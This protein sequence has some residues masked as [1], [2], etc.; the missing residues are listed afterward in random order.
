MKKQLLALSGTV[1]FVGGAVALSM[2]SRAL[3]NDSP[4]PTATEFQPDAMSRN[5]APRAKTQIP[6]ETA[7][8]GY[9]E[10][11]TDLFA[12]M[13]AGVYRNDE[14]LDL[15]ARTWSFSLGGQTT[16]N[17]VFGADSNGNFCNLSENEVVY[18]FTGTI[19]ADKACSVMPVFLVLNTDTSQF[20]IY[21]GT[22]DALTLNDENSLTATFTTRM[23]WTGGNNLPMGVGFYTED[24]EAT[25]FTVTDM[26]FSTIVRGITAEQWSEEKDLPG[27]GL[28]DSWM[29]DSEKFMARDG[30]TT[31]GLCRYGEDY[32]SLSGINT[33][34]TDVTIPEKAV[35]GGKV[36]HIR[37]N[38]E[39]VSYNGNPDWS[40]AASMTT[41][42]FYSTFETWY[43]SFNGSSVSDVFIEGRTLFENTARTDG[44][45][46]YL[47]I[48]KESVSIERRYY[49]GR[50]FT[51]VFVGEETA[52]YPQTD[53]SHYIIANGEGDYFGLYLYDNYIYVAEVFS[54]KENVSLPY[55]APYDGR[56]IWVSGAGL[57]DLI[58]YGTF[59]AH[60]PGMKAI[61]LSEHYD[62]IDI[63]WNYSPLLKELYV[64]GSP[65]NLRWSLNNDMKV[66]VGVQQ[67]FS[68]YEA[69]SNWNRAAI[70]PYGWDFEWMTVN[71]GRKGEFAQTYIEMT[72]ADW[73]VGTLVKITGE[74]NQADLK[75][76]KNLV[77]L[78]NLD[79]TEA[80]FENLPDNFLDHCNT[81]RIVSLPESLLMIPASAFSNCG[82]LTTV[83][84]PGVMSVDYNA[85]YYCSNLTGFD[86]S[87]VTYIGN[88]AFYNC[89]KYEP[90]AFNE[91]LSYIGSSAFRYTDVR[92]VVI[93]AGV[94]TLSSYTFANCQNLR[95]ILLPETLTKIES[96]A[97]A[98]CPSLVTLD[99]PEGVTSIGR[100]AFEYCSGLTEISLPSTL[101]EIGYNIFY[102]NSALATVKC[103]AVVP[104]LAGG[105]FLSGVD[106]NHCNLYVAPFCIDAYRE[107]DYWSEFYIMKALMEPV[108]NILVNRP[109][110]F[111]LLSEDNAVL[112]DNPNMTLDYGSGSSNVG[113]LYAEG[114][115]TLSAGVFYI[116]H[117][118]YNRN[119]SYYNDLR[120]TLVN[121]AENMRADSVVCSVDLA[122]NVWHFVSFQYDVQM[123]DIYG[124][125][126]TDFVV[127]QYNSERRATGDGTV[128]NWEPV[129]ADGVLKAGRGYIVQ[130]ANNT[131]NENGNSRLAVVR[132]PS[133]NT[134]SKNN[135]FTNRNIIVPLDEYPAEFAHNRSWNLVGNPYPCYYNM[136]SLLENFT[137]PVILWR[138][139]SYQAYSPVD[140]DIILRPNEAFFV[141][142]PLDAEN[143]VFGVD[144]RMDYTAANS[145]SNLTPGS[146]A[147]EASGISSRAVFNFNVEGCGSDDRTRVVI[148]EEALAGYEA[149]RDASKFFAENNDAVEFYSISDT[150]YDICE[151]P[152]GDA[153][154][155]LGARFAKAGEYTISLSG[156]NIDGWK[157]TLVD[158]VEEVETDLTTADYTF[159]AESGVCEGRFIIRFTPACPSLVELVEADS[160]ARVTVVNMTGVKVFEGRLGDFTAATAGVYVVIGENASHKV[161]VK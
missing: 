30:E 17:Y 4:K 37:D 150:K 114:D 18:E 67:F 157:A 161:I 104:P 143:I 21:P 148:N 31:F 19:T 42:Y 77:N 101:Q 102:Q 103:K 122:K 9:S 68:D 94:N 79:L 36:Y 100:E 140:D 75:N 116:R 11:V 82:N 13:A 132:F 153:E 158:T 3:S 160:E 22:S 127:R 52:E 117:K 121:N 71:V 33:T 44:T 90:A 99:I 136:H 56:N 96:E 53:K 135:L 54:D 118:M 49:E 106:L 133:R 12:Q 74:L 113:Q 40:G 51:R 10:I 50:G 64:N 147:P 20:S 92:E 35:I 62:K 142:R 23:N 72:D 26:T 25:N 27:L 129:P 39:M 57:D 152:L 47:H 28:K 125:N 76:I 88:S 34:E 86:I 1:L 78:R 155:R 119:D 58:S 65:A 5:L 6:R 45:D 84:A 60:A 46:I 66:Y 61:T 110:T 108:K 146:R 87:N 16:A 48:T 134:T 70:E 93:P 2:G 141:Q 151:R 137:A 109:M 91:S 41:I 111:N 98:S 63:S 138:G 139:S 123:A 81:V 105:S 85:F 124:L 154:V 32:V 89:P 24:T 145:N 15:A 107:A 7:P 43:G 126:G 112:Q 59:V 80:Q 128:S 97:L 149:G 55:D 73:S 69:D 14:T 95:S 29:S 115:G 120:T 8:E 130:A 38:A 156:K 159:Q 144:G 131:V 83:N